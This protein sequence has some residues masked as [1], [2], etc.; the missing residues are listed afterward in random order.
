MS[1]VKSLVYLASREVFYHCFGIIDSFAYYSQDYCL[2]FL[3]QGCARGLLARKDYCCIC[4]IS[5]HYSL[6]RLNEIKHNSFKLERF[7]LRI[8]RD[9]AEMLSIEPTVFFWKNDYY[10]WVC[11]A[12]FEGGKGEYIDSF[13]ENLDYLFRSKSIKWHLIE[14]IHH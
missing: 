13:K 8:L 5:E 2:C 14:P 11:F 9:V 1:C 10:N 7:Q 6:E 4:R 12:S 3:Y